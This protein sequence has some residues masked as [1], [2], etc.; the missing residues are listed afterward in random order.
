M[1]RQFAGAR[2]KQIAA[3]ANVVAEIEQLVQLE[4][5]VADRVFLHVNLQPL[6]VLLQMAR[7]PPCPSGESP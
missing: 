3:D 4:T 6:S 5:L 2:A 7:I 1:D